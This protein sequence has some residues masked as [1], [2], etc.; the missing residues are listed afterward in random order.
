MGRTVRSNQLF[1]NGVSVELTPIGRDPVSPVTTGDLSA[2]V[3]RTDEVS[4]ADALT[5]DDLA[6]L[7][8]SIAGAGPATIAV[9][10]GG[11][12]DAVAEA[13]SSDEDF[14]DNRRVGRVADLS[15]HA[16]ILVL[17]TSLNPVSHA[18]VARL[19]R[20]CPDVAVVL[21]PVERIADAPVAENL[22]ASFADRVRSGRWDVLGLVGGD[23]ARAALRQLGASAIQIVDSVVE[24]VPLAVVV[25][26]SVDG[27]P[28]F[29]KAGGFGGE[30]T[31][32]DVVTRL[33]S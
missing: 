20:A 9:G 25:G 28:V 2:L 26:G 19:N 22:A 5:D 11:L 29:T 33:R 16:H 15:R 6:A 27:M 13:W 17:V 7:A 24:G 10:S 4:T 31:L 1:V 21:A 8:R 12:A 3:P 18:Q 32:V 23:G 30:D 14:P